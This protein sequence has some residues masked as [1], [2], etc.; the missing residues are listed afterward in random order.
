MNDAVVLVTGG[1]GNVGRAVTR[2]FLEAGARVAVPVYTTDL[3]DSLAPESG[4]FGGRI[5]TFALDLTTERGAEA[6]IRDVLEWGGRLDVLV[7]M[8]GGYDGGVELADTSLELWDRMIDLNL[9]SAFLVVRAALPHMLD[10]GGG[11]L[12]FISSRAARS[13]GP[14]HGAYAVAKSALITFTQVVAEEYR[15]RG[16]RANVVLPGTVDTEANRQAMPDQDPA[17]WVRPEEIAATI[18]FLASPA[19]SAINGASVPV[20][21]RS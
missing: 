9:K 13:I 7:H 10:A 1:A 15:D 18:L 2:R 11:S 8:V 4:E 5:H 14:G 3:P 12:V 17:D 19:S 6:A 20:Y 21:G 16:I